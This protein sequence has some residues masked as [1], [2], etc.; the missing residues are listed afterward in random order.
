MITI[1]FVGWIAGRIASLQPV[2]SEISDLCEISDL[3]LFIS[4]LLQTKGIKFGYSFF[5]VCRAN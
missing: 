5:D 2:S 3:V 1:R 4:L